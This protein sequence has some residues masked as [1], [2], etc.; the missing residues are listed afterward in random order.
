M[1]CKTQPKG[2]IK[3]FSEPHQVNLRARLSCRYLGIAGYITLP[4]PRATGEVP[5]D[6]E[7]EEEAFG[8]TELANIINLFLGFILAY[9]LLH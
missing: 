7:S 8:T 4:L 5:N 2:K 6:S 1:V 3:F 9:P